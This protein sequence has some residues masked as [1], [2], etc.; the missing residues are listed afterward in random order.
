MP[1]PTI[2]ERLESRESVSTEQG[3]SIVRHFQIENTNDPEQ[4]FNLGLLPVYG[5]AHPVFPSLSVQ[6]VRVEI[7]PG[8]H[9]M[10]L[11]HVTYGTDQGGLYNEHGEIWE[12]D[13]ASEQ[14]RITSVLKPADQ[15]HFPPEFNTGTAIGV[16]G[17]DVE[18]VDVYRPNLVVR[19]TKRYTSLPSSGFRRGIFERVSTINA[20]G[21]WGF[22]AGELLCLGAQ[23]RP[24][25]TGEWQWSVAYNFLAAKTL[26]EQ[27][28]T[29]ENGQTIAINGSP[30][31]YLWFTYNKKT[32]NAGATPY[33]KNGIE[34]I[35]L[36]RVYE[37]TDF[38]FF[39]L[40][41]P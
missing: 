32:A 15:A 41:G 38:G 9:S 29:L 36:A 13:F 26:T 6:E 11:A 10:L 27:Q 35:H 7:M 37:R 40:Q 2:T 30:W 8:H 23:L 16:S 33:V 28:V 19:V 20:G 22:H 25:G 4:A 24:I 5:D 12:W 1:S 18:G 17:D 34:A 31:D 21:V 14:R 39:G 3:L